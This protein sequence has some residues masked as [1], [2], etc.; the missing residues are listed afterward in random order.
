[1][2]STINI[3]E[4]FPTLLVQKNETKKQ[5]TERSSSVGSSVSSSSVGAFRLQKTNQFQ[6]IEA[7]PNGQYTAVEDLVVRP[8]LK[9]HCER[10]GC[11]WLTKRE[12]RKAKCQRATKVKSG[13]I[14]KVIDSKV[15][16]SQV[17]E[18]R[19]KFSVALIQWEVD[20]K[21]QYT[22]DISTE[23]KQGWCF[24]RCLMALELDEP[25]QITPQTRKE[26]SLMALELVEPQQIT[27][28]TRKE[29]S[30]LVN[31]WKTRS[32]STT[33]SVSNS[34]QEINRSRSNSVASNFET[35]ELK[36]GEPVLAKVG[37]F[38]LKAVV[39]SVNPLRAVVQTTGQSVCNASN[40]K[41]AASNFV[42]FKLGEPV[43][44]RV[45]GGVFWEKAVIR[46][47]N[48]LRAVIQKTGQSVTN[49]SDIMKAETNDFVVTRD[50][51]VRNTKLD[52]RWAVKTGA[53]TS[54]TVVSVAEV[55][56]IDAYVTS[57]VCGWI[58]M[59]SAHAFNA[60]NVNIFRQEKEPTIYVENLPADMT[61]KEL[62]RKITLRYKVVPK[63]FR[64]ESSGT[65]YRAVLTLGSH[66]QALQLATKKNF[67]I[68]QKCTVVFSWDDQYL[69][70]HALSSIG[71]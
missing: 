3:T 26:T 45:G 67:L 6:K 51:P 59:R 64:F 25:Q 2:M 34:P 4:E 36:L 41:K 29:T 7:I 9:C 1:M 58:T 39:R 42:G 15:V 62:K 10:C 19:L 53:L 56:G 71:Y 50:I 54:G 38:W 27:P 16:H 61:E 24:S 20:V 11:K 55:D 14:C 40:I 69:R 46:D 65:L 13:L 66:E 70:L 57:P 17:G 48:P 30:L 49:I 47:V 12:W 60:V 18:K 63:T 22:G 31:P 68:R 32:K 52:D 28:Q 35:S 44:A 43:L 37:A 23:F 21:C 8:Y 33:L 5:Q